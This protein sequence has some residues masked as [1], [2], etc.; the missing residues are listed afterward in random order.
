[1]ITIYGFGPAF[2]LSDASPFVRKT[3]I[4]LKL[5]NLPYQKRTGKLRLAPKGKLPYIEDQ[6]VILS[7]STFI[8]WHLEKTY[9]I[10]LDAGLSSQ[11][12]GVAWALEKLVEDH[13]YW[14][15]VQR[16]WRDPANYRKVAAV[17]F[18]KLPWPLRPLVS[19]LASRQAGQRLWV[20]GMGRHTPDEQLALVRNTVASIAAILGDQAFMLGARPSTV[21]AAVYPFMESMTSDYFDDRF[22]AI[23]RSH[24]N[25]LRYVAAMRA[26]IDFDLPER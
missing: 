3:E 5:A 4:L 12:R 10:D 9:R 25:L 14:A 16:A 6:G 17:L 13:L 2:G 19:Y 21:D 15:L 1:M 24:P 20:Q 8:R 7:D 11:Q 22:T 23:M 26:Q 18:K